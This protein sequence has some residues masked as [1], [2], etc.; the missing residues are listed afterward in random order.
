MTKQ[1][2]INKEFWKYSIH[3]KLSYS[4]AILAFSIQFFI[5]IRYLSTVFGQLCLVEAV[6]A[7]S[8]I[9]V[10]DLIHKKRAVYPK[11]FKPIHPDLFIRFVI[12]FGA[13]A[14]IQAIFQYVP[15]TL[16]ESEIALAIVFCGVSE[17]FVFRGIM[18]EPFFRLG[19][20]DKKKYHLWKDYW[21]SVIEIYGILIS[22]TLFALFHFNY[23]ENLGLGL[24]VIFGGFWLG[25]CYW[26]WKDIT[27]VIFAHVLLNMIFVIQTY[28]QVVFI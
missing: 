22:G 27:A 21:I 19:I 18:M 24:T 23:Y 9:L 12:I 16:R 11:R 26:Y 1:E 25:F 10:L 28:W 3:T 15:I 7:L 20:K 17:E 8:G 5:G 13:I 14:V 4:M 6:F 2:K